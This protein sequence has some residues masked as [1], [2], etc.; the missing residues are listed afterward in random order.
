MEDW[1][2]YS[3]RCRPDATRKGVLS[4]SMGDLLGRKVEVTYH[5][6]LYGLRWV[7]WW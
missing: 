7:L 2:R 3:T 6:N 1:R 5:S 4:S